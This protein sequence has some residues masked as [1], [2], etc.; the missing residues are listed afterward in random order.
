MAF[1]VEYAYVRKEVVPPGHYT[2]P[3]EAMLLANMTKF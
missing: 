1:G 3:S 2:M